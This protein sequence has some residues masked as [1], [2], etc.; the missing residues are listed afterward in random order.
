MAVAVGPRHGGVGGGLGGAI[1]AGV[2]TALSLAIIGGLALACFTKAAGAVFLGEP[3]GPAPA[4][5][6]ES[7][8][9]M[10]GPMITLAVLLSLIHL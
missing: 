3:R 6:T 5:A 8:R 4:N 7:P 9:A 10:L 2:V 1:W